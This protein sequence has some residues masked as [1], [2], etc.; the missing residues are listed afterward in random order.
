MRIA[1]AAGLAVLALAACN[2]NSK[3]AQTTTQKPQAGATSTTFSHKNFKTMPDAADGASGSGCLADTGPLPDGAWFGFVSAWNASGIE[4]D[5]AC[6]YDGAPAAKQAADRGEESPP[7]NDFFIANDSKALRH[8]DVAAG[9]PAL[10]VTHDKNGSVTEENTTYGDLVANSGT[11]I[12]CPGEGCALWVYVNG[13]QVTE[14]AMQYL[15]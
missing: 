15:P 7:P 6:W 4:L 10:R 5:A 11:Y 8:I 12:T 13:G 14:V 3:Q 1:L 2:S 9:V